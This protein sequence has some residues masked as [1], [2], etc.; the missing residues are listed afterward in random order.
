MNEKKNCLICSTSVNPILCI[1][2]VV[3]VVGQTCTHTTY[4]CKKSIIKVKKKILIEMSLDDDNHWIDKKKDRYLTQMKRM[5]K[6]NLGV[7]FGSKSLDQAC[8]KK[9]LESS[10]SCIN[11][12]NIKCDRTNKNI[13][14]IDRWWHIIIRMKKR[15]ISNSNSKKRKISAWKQIFEYFVAFRYY[16]R[17]KFLFLK[18]FDNLTD[19]YH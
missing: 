2:A 3:V 10:S 13:D 15:H 14:W 5:T 8:V 19:F 12:R 4:I 11:I 17:K 18:I 9:I 7:L 1:F 16:H 6:K